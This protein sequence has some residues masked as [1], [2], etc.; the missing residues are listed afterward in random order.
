MAGRGAYSTDS[1]S[2]ASQVCLVLSNLLISQGSV[3][4]R[5]RWSKKKDIR[6]EYLPFVMLMGA[7]VVRREC[8]HALKACLLDDLLELYGELY[9]RRICC[10][11]LRIHGSSGAVSCSVRN[12]IIR[13]RRKHCSEAYRPVCR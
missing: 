7:I 4:R 11:R 6:S 5:R 9:E 1:E 8:R 10:V 12:K 13:D 2:Q 3:N